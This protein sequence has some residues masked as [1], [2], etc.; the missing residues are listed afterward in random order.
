MHACSPNI[1]QLLTQHIDAATQVFGKL[2]PQVLSA[3]HQLAELYQLTGRAEQAEQLFR[4]TLKARASVLGA[5]HKD[6]QETQKQLSALL[7]NQK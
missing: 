7:S 2:H 5:S 3:S 1:E 6:T 4:Q